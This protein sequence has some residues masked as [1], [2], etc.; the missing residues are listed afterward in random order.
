MVEGLGNVRDGT[1]EEH[2]REGRA[3]TPVVVSV[4]ARGAFTLIEL[5]VVISIIALLIALLLPAVK[6]AKVAARNVMCQ[7]NLRQ[8][9][10]ALI[11]YAGDFDRYPP[12]IPGASGG[13]LGYMQDEAAYWLDAGFNPAMFYCPM[14]DDFELVTNRLLMWNPRLARLGTF[15]SGFEVEIGYAKPAGCAPDD[16]PVGNPHYNRLY[17]SPP[18]DPKPVPLR[19]DDPPFWVTLADRIGADPVLEPGR[20]WGTHPIGGGNSWFSW[21]ECGPTVDCWVTFT[22]DQMAGGNV[23]SNDASVK[24][25]AF[26]DMETNYANGTAF[27]YW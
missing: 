18:L 20:V 5:L 26:D 14:G 6:R 17:V 7:S 13:V 10:I 21:A 23:A 24:W 1:T 9:Q 27:N 19:P 25:K 4:G 15:G 2:R 3:F 22:L 11:S 12:N 16:P 8:H